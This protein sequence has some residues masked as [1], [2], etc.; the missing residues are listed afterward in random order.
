MLCMNNRYDIEYA[1]YEFAKYS[2]I[3]CQ[4]FLNLYEQ[5]NELTES[6]LSFGTMVSTAL[7]VTYARPFSGSN[8]EYHG[9]KM[10]AI[11]EK[12]LKKLSDKHR[13]THAY[14]VGTGRNALAAHIDLGKLMPNIFV[15]DGGNN[16]FVFDMHLPMINENTVN[17]YSELV[18]AAL[19]Y[20]REHQQSIRAHLSGEHL[21]PEVSHPNASSF[22]KRSSQKK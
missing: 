1:K 4:N 11:S 5:L 7:V 2:F 20:C 6:K 13:E 12:W 15:K 19:N 14:L 21:V 9:F 3:E 10:G 16:D 18:V 22:I 8:K 17:L